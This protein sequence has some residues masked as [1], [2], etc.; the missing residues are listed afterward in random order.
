MGT[1]YWSA[2]KRE[3]D[4]PNNV[5]GIELASGSFATNENTSAK[6]AEAIP[7]EADYVMV[8]LTEA[9]F[10]KLGP[11]ADVTANKTTSIRQTDLCLWYAIKDGWGFAAIDAA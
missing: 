5:M 10:I 11:Q 8:S 3:E 9:G 6:T 2:F 4:N 1:L 7:S